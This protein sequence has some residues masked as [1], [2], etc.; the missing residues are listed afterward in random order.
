[1]WRVNLSFSLHFLFIS[2]F[3]LH[4]FAS[5][6]CS[7]F[8]NPGFRGRKGKLR[9]VKGEIMRL[10]G[11]CKIRT[12]SWI[13]KHT[14]SFTYLLDT[15]TVCLVGGHHVTSCVIHL[16][17]K[18][19]P[20]GAQCQHWYINKWTVFAFTATFFRQVRKGYDIICLWFDKC[21]RDFYICIYY[22]ASKSTTTQGG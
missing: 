14:C 17:T 12:W 7:E 5:R 21:K 2:L 8:R 19:L 16:K 1:M 18:R 20:D 4:F 10:E 9:N 15:A 6:G 13:F 22:S 3:S 11:R